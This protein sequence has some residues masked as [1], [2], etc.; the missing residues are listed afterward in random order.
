VAK[1]R[2]KGRRKRQVSRPVQKAVATPTPENPKKPVHW[3]KRVSAAYLRL[4]G[5][6][7]VE[8]A[9]AV[10]AGERTILRWESEDSWPAAQAE[11]RSRWLQGC[12]SLAMR[13]LVNGLKADDQSTA[14]WWAGKRI[15]ELGG[16]TAPRAP[17]GVGEH[18]RRFGVMLTPDQLRAMSLEQLEA[19][20]AALAL[21]GDAESEEQTGDPG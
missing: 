9:K 3:D 10:K 13:A 19:L 2:K 11:A 5:H 17:G 16:S 21:V 7:Q 15:K 4:L 12:D 14:R 1:K 18:G 20:D 6:T 8:T